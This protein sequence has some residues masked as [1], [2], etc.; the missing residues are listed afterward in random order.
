[1]QTFKVKLESMWRFSNDDPFDE[2]EAFIYSFI[3]VPSSV[4]WCMKKEAA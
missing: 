2:K 1:M 4:N 3:H